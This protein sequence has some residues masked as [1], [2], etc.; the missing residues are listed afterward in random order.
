MFMQT[1]TQ[2]WP[3]KSV[4]AALCA[5]GLSSL[6]GSPAQAAPDGH[7]LYIHHCNAC[8]QL[9]G[10]GD[11]GLPLTAQ[12]L[13]EVSDDYLFNS[14]RAGRPGRIMPAFE[15][16]SDAQVLAIVKF[17]RTRTGTESRNFSAVPLAGNPEHGGELYAQHC[18]RC[19]ADDGSGD[20]NGTGVTL[21]RDRGFMVM[22]PAI[23]NPGFLASIT[24]AQLRHTIAIGREQSGM[25]AFGKMGL[26]EQDMN[27][28][29]AYVRELGES[30]ARPEADIDEPLSQVVES[31]YDF[32]TT[33]A[34]LR[35]AASSANFRVFPDRFLE[36]GLFDEFSV[37]KHQAGVRFCNFKMLYG[38]IATEP[39]LGVVLPCRI[40]VL[41]QPDGQ[42]IMV[43]PNLRVVSRWFNNDELVELWEAMQET[44]NEIVE[45]ATL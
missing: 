42:V 2:R 40:S 44:L 27:D 11:I 12:K 37:N 24:D 29:V 38:L 19:H 13:A 6:L 43:T 7:E 36:Q 32:K 1:S 28:L 25:P 8:H 21:S 22:P 33:M 5:V 45:E 39:R 31:P 17:L 26:S 4:L 20:G 23:S 34:N 41:E 35:Q 10:A 30:T 18:V 3:N 15:K 9:D 16:M 14:I